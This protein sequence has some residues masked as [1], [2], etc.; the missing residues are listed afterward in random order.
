MAKKCIICGDKAEFC[1]KGSS[2]FYCR[3]C[4][5]EQF[6]D[7]NMLVKVEEEAQKLK[8]LVDEKVN[9]DE[10]DGVQ[11]EAV[12]DETGQDE[13][14]AGLPSGEADDGEEHDKEGHQADE[15]DPAEER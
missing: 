7:I 6:G 11:D 10:D 14:D 3:E 12:Q 4:A 2:E 1:I 8:R 5:E 9:A 15:A 13:G